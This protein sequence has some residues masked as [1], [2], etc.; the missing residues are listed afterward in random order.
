MF[1]FPSLDKQDVKRSYRLEA[2]ICLFDD[3]PKALSILSMM[4]HG[5]IYLSAGK[6]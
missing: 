4:F 2:F 3:V 5:P 1:N 6:M